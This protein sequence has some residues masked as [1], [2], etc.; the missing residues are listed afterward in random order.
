MTKKLAS[1]KETLA[2]CGRRKLGAEI[3]FFYYAPFSIIQVNSR[4][5]NVVNKKLH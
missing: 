4:D 1:S 2:S 5:M 3:M